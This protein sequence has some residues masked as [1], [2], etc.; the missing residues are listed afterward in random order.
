MTSPN[1]WWLLPLHSWRL[2]INSNSSIC[3]IHLGCP[4][5]SIRAVSR[6]YVSTCNSYGVTLLPMTDPLSQ[7]SRPSNYCLDSNFSNDSP[8]STYKNSIPNNQQ[9]AVLHMIIWVP[10]IYP[11]EKMHKSFRSFAIVFAWRASQRTSF[12]AH[13]SGTRQYRTIPS[14]LLCFPFGPF[15]IA[16]CW[17]FHG[18]W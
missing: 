12:F 3:T 6:I 5:L 7:N 1:S 9:I 17:N 11:Y 18:F 8:A 2:N 14:A 4:V 16:L 10:S 13:F 15:V